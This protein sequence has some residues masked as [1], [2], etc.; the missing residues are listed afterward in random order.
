[1]QFGASLSFFLQ[2][3]QSFTIKRQCFVFIRFD[4]L[5]IFFSGVP[6]TC[7][8]PLWEHLPE[9]CINHLLRCL[10]LSLDCSMGES[11]RRHLSE[12]Q[13]CL[14]KWNWE[15]GWLGLYLQEESSRSKK[16]HS[17]WT[18]WIEKWFNF[19]GTLVSAPPNLF[20]SLFPIGYGNVE[21]GTLPHTTSDHQTVF[22]LLSIHRS[23]IA[24]QR[25]GVDPRKRRWYFLAGIGML[26]TA[27]A[28]VQR[29][30]CLGEQ[31]QSSGTPFGVSQKHQISRVF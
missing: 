23:M 30:H 18:L 8:M 25:S 19:R 2:F 27:V 20:P 12:I 13:E 5:T 22:G 24:P 29:F 7:Y 1:M 28:L 26:S 10:L 3:S 14:A 15:H 31:G 11:P 21:W 4:Q 9:T 16:E 6:Y 17:Q